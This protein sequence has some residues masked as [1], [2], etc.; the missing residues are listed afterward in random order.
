MQQAQD[1]ILSTGIAAITKVRGRNALFASR[2]MQEQLVAFVDKRLQAGDETASVEKVQR[3]IE[4]CLRVLPDDLLGV[5]PDIR[6]TAV[7]GSSGEPTARA[8]W[9]RAVRRS[10]MN[11]TC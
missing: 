8:A 6:F 7:L 9:A 3:A 1:P 4:T 11:F 2:L 10:Q 5:L